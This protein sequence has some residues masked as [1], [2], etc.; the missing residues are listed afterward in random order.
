MNSQS[1]IHKTAIFCLVF[2]NFVR[3]CLIQ[4]KQPP[5]GIRI[6]SVFL[7]PVVWFGSLGAVAPTNQDSILTTSQTVQG[8]GSVTI[9]SST[10]P[11]HELWLAPSG[12]TVFTEG[13]TMTK[14]N[15]TATTI[16]AP[17]DE[18]V[19]Y[20]F[21]I[22]TSSE[23]SD[24]SVATVTVD[25]TSPIIT[26][27]NPDQTAAA[28]SRTFTA[29]TNEGTLEMVTVS[30]GICDATVNGFVAYA[31]VV[32]SAESDN[33]SSVCYQATDTAGNTAYSLSDTVTGIDTTAP[34]ITINNPDQTAA[35]QSRTFT[36]S[37]NEGIL[38]MVTV[39][40]GICDATLSGF[41]AYAEVIFSAESDNGSS[42]CY[43][44]TD[45]AG[46]TAYSLS[47]TVTG[48]D[49]TA[50]TITITNPDQ[51]T[52]DQDRTFTATVS[53]GTLLM[54]TI[55]GD[56]CDASV[57]T[58]EAYA[59]VTFSAESDNGRS[60][61][62]QATDAVGNVSY[63]QSEKVTKLDTSGPTITFTDDVDPVLN[64]ADTISITVYESVSD[65]NVYGF[66]ADNICDASDSYPNTFGSGSFVI[67]TEDYNGNHICARA[68]D[69]AGNIAYQ[70]SANPLN[71]DTTAPTI[72][73]NNPDQTAAAQS[74]TFTASTSDGTLTMATVLDGVC[75]ATVSGF[76]AYAEV[77]F[78]AE[79][80]NGSRICYQ[81]TD[82]LGNTAYELSDTVTEID[83]TAPTI[84]ITNPDQSFSAQSREF[85]AS[86]S[87]GTLTMAIIS[88]GICDATVSSFEAYAEV[89][90]SAENDNGSRICYQATDDL[91]NT[92]Y[93]LSDEVTGID[94]TAPT[95]RFNDDVD[96][97]LN[98]A[99]T[100]SITVEDLNS[101]VHFYGF[102][103]D[104]FC[105]ETDSYPYDF[106]SGGSFVI[107]NESY[108]GQYLCI[109]AEDEAENFAYQISS[110]A[111][112]IDSTL[113]A[114][115]AIDIYHTE[116]EVLVESD[117][118][119]KS[120]G[121]TV[122]PTFYD[123]NLDT[124]EYTFISGAESC[125]DSASGWSDYLLPIILDSEDYN[126]QEL[127][128]RATD[129]A[130]NTSYLASGI[131]GGLDYSPPVISITEIDQTA[132]AQS[133]EFSATIDEENGLLSVTENLFQTILADDQQACDDTTAQEFTPYEVLTFS[134]E[135]ENG[136][137]ICYE[138]VDEFG[139][140]SYAVSDPVANIDRTPP[141]VVSTT[142]TDEE[143]E[144]NINTSLVVTLSESISLLDLDE[145][146]TVTP[147]GEDTPEAV[148]AFSDVTL[149]DETITIALPND[150]AEN[151]VYT[152]YVPAESWQDSAENI[153]TTELSWSFQTGAWKAF[154]TAPW[155]DSITN[156]QANLRLTSDEEGSVYYL[157]STT[158]L[159]E[160][161]PLATDIK[162]NPTGT[163][164]VQAA[165]E[166]IETITGLDPYTNYWIAIVGEDTSGNLQPDPTVVSFIT[167]DIALNEINSTDFDADSVTSFQDT[168]TDLI[169]AQITGIPNDLSALESVSD[170][171]T[172]YAVKN[173]VVFSNN[174][175]SGLSAPYLFASAQRSASTDNKKLLLAIP[176]GARFNQTNI[177]ISP[178]VIG[179]NPSI[180]NFAAKVTMEVPTNEVVVVS[181]GV[182]EL[183]V[184]GTTSSLGVSTAEQVDLYYQSQGSTTWNSETPSNPRFISSSG[185]FC[186][187]SSHLTKFAL[188]V[189]SEPTTTT[190]TSS[191][192]GGGGGGGS[193][194][195][196]SSSRSQAVVYQ[197]QK[198][199]EVFLVEKWLDFRQ[200]EKATQSPIRLLSSIG[201]YL[202]PTDT[203]IT[204]A[205][206]GE[207]FTDVL[208]LPALNSALNK[209][210]PEK[211]TAFSSVLSIAS[212]SEAALNFSRA[213]ELTIP[214]HKSFSSSYEEE[215]RAYAYQNQEFVP[216]DRAE[217][218]ADK[219]S[220]IIRSQ[221]SGDFVVLGPTAAARSKNLIRIPR[222]ELST[223]ELFSAPTGGEARPLFADLDQAH[224]SHNFI[225]KLVSW[226]IID[227]YPDGS[228]R[229]SS[230]LNKAEI[231]KMI[232]LTFELPTAEV[233]FGQR[234]FDPYLAV[235]KEY[236]IIN[237][238]N[239]K[240][241]QAI[242]RGEMMRML[243][244]A[245]GFRYNLTGTPFTDVPLDHPQFSYLQTARNLGIIDGY[246][247]G[248]F[249][250]NKALNR[251]EA[252][253]IITL[254]KEK[255][256]E[257]QALSM[258]P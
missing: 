127:C 77:V 9:T 154:S 1:D 194:G 253:K 101:T 135:E 65:Q 4:N 67:E 20:L 76:V 142:P 95:I 143:N 85:E 146:I 206:T 224:W 28:Q 258:E 249:R 47:D 214:L 134:A 32:F 172:V 63:L 180:T 71:L 221:V 175:S 37:T 52:S 140:T 26:I 33:G 78:S 129:Q 217:L 144:V 83:T 251:A 151:T 90:F 40:N 257:T 62:Y 139:N 179:N 130:E 212:R 116:D 250:P 112:N 119:T 176:Q 141:T 252:A 247:D 18:G 178:P 105:D 225:G 162:D 16:L 30:N 237:V 115:G 70:A 100:I 125:D 121:K 74:R 60:V 185:Q 98:N 106:I 2:L 14:T 93:E 58:F 161:P 128:F 103:A 184:P 7:L 248:S 15:G 123:S 215:I 110:D 244:K 84:T 153:S 201:D 61:C 193:I 191:G 226:G 25:N 91:G 87:D 148:I 13:S 69:Q 195:Y 17:A 22:N 171:S 197:N 99:D 149:E 107:D 38:E 239:Y 29:S 27:N 219:K 177:E 56:S 228:F 169:S 8:G 216:V 203:T 167:Q 53:D 202:I 114:V 73:I 190:T 152:V 131:I 242:S 174:S 199:D 246:P 181:D 183:C 12:T 158:D 150:L 255:F 137:V 188:G 157:V 39:S 94:T 126:G 117:F 254:A 34:T 19:Y 66:S 23:I 236:T 82:D 11:S 46:N 64:N 44:A 5:M 166:I 168:K 182:L 92:A 173:P 80:D 198:S 230:L 227:G 43:Q 196:S 160:A 136:Q 241:D 124:K 10:D 48:I 210:I 3:I 102:S 233:G 72:T 132:P 31:E 204:Y 213:Y 68:T 42:V 133:R 189:Y 138:A 89:V 231:S 79:N 81:A 21:V 147:E 170:D 57:G 24:A 207:G 54:V 113:P 165:A 208:K 36:A 192:G 109:E 120:R 96:P 155:V 118:N 88:D 122:I 223:V 186:W 245:G 234:W 211:L 229:P 45:T 256:L 235:L 35:A 163:L 49:T 86:V 200:V 55:W 97:V 59:E 6:L 243:I 238:R 164:A 205:E 51:T 209:E 104:N 159:T 240:V 108:N 41:V 222:E 232:A 50:P 156:T 111:L 75:D 145:N 218:S 187:E 220:M